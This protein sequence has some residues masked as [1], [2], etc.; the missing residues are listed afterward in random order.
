MG[1]NLYFSKNYFVTQGFSIYMLHIEKFSMNYLNGSRD[2]TLKFIKEKQG[3]RRQFR[4]SA[5]H[6]AL[7]QMNLRYADLHGRLPLSTQNLLLEIY[8]R[9]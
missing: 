4:F 6:C 2:Y 7:L 8:C 1:K 9:A 3:I 5:I